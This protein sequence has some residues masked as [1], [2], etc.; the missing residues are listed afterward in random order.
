MILLRIAL[1]MVFASA[2]LLL[3]GVAVSIMTRD[4]W[5]I[6][7]HTAGVISAVIAALA[8][9]LLC[10]AGVRRLAPPPGRP[11]RN[12]TLDQRGM[13]KVSMPVERSVRGGG[14]GT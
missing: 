12:S 10:A 13:D 2:M 9:L 11:A 8:V 5:L 7:A 6:V 14:G 4:A 1:R 3:G